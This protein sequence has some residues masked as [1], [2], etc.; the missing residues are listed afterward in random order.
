MPELRRPT[1]LTHA[2]AEASMRRIELSGPQIQGQAG[3]S[4]GRLSST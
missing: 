2:T 1:Q 3:N 4:E